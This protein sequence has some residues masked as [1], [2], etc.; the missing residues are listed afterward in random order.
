[1]SSASTLVRLQQLDALAA[2]LADGELHTVASLAG[3]LGVSPRTLARYLA[4]LRARGFQIDASIGPG[5][6]IQLSPQS[7]TPTLVFKESQAIELLLAVAVSDALGLSLSTDLAEVRMQLARGFAPADRRRIG[8]LRQRIRVCGAVSH[9]VQQTRQTEPAG[10]RRAVHAAFVRHRQLSIS[11]ADGKGQRTHRLVEPH[12][13]LLAF[14]FW[15][16]LAWDPERQGIRTFRMDRIGSARV[17]EASFPLRPLS[18]FWAHCEDV[19]L[20]L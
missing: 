9:V 10:V 4:L 16:I 13:L 7:R 6:G 17:Q 1:M 3:A 20:G 11:Y 5:G 14:P 12:A 19:G 15:Y 18:P 8:Q 2:L